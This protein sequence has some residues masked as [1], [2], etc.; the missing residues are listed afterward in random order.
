MNTDQEIMQAFVDYERTQFGGWPWEAEAVVFPQTK[1]RFAL[2]NGVETTP[3]TQAQT[4]KH[5]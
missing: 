2:L 4:A 3:P 1:G 5:R